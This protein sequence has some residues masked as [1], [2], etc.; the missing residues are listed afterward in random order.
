MEKKKKKK[1]PARKNA[2]GGTKEVQQKTTREK[3][4]ESWGTAPREGQTEGKRRICWEGGRRKTQCRSG[5]LGAGKDNDMGAVIQRKVQVVKKKRGG[6]GK[7]KV[8]NNASNH[9]TGA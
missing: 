1:G 8:T 6:G 5:N 3:K 9:P 7:R 4:Q 2:V